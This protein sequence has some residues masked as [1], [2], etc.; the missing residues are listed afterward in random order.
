[1]VMPPAQT[2]PLSEPLPTS[3]QPVVNTLPVSNQAQ[4][5]N[6]T[7][8]EPAV[9]IEFKPPVA[10]SNPTPVVNKSDNK[11]QI[12]IILLLLILISLIL[13]FAVI[14]YYQLQKDTLPLIKNEQQNQEQNQTSPTPSTQAVEG[15]GFFSVE[16]PRDN[17]LVN[18]E[19]KVHFKYTG[20]IDALKVA[21]YDDNNVLLGSSDQVLD[22]VSSENLKQINLDIEKSPTA[23]TGSINLIPVYKNS[24]L[25]NLS[26][27]VKV[28]FLT[29]EAGD[30]IKLY[31]PI[32]RQVVYKASPELQLGGQ[33]HDFFEGVMNYRL[34][35]STGT[36]L[37][38]GFVQATDDNYMGFVSF[39]EKLELE[40]FPPD[41]SD[42]GRLEL[43]EVSM[44]DGSEKVLLSVPLRFK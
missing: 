15:E 34:V 41:T 35:S 13:G 22:E 21:I 28:K 5:V 9:K 7:P 23:T 39:Q 8:E 27:E 2:T 42:N 20:Q 6:P 1:M 16:L 36:L 10:P 26:K 12:I 43:Y 31:S 32:L 25:G 11:F 24:E 30:R 4:P 17:D 29:L 33:M 19:I 14:F 37:K 18:G 44:Q 3:P 40:Q 38:Q